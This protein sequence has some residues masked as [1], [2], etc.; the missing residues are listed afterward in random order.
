M[1]SYMIKWNTD[2]Y[3]NITKI[4]HMF[5]REHK[6]YVSLDGGRDQVT[7][8]NC[9]SDE[10]AKEK[11][12][13]LLR[14]INQNSLIEKIEAQQE[15]INLLQEQINELY[16]ELYYRPNGPGFEQAKEHFEKNK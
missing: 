5:R 2:S 9:G 8:L 12:E 14:E 4:V 7:I 13:Y 6:I 1:G 10:V 11:F 16:N 3:I 15:Q